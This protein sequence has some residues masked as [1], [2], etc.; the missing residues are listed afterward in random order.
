MPIHTWTRRGFWVFA[1]LHLTLWTIVPICIQPNPPLD[2]VEVVA[3]GHE[4]ELGYQKHPP[5]VAWLAEVARLA[6]GTD[7]LWP[8]Y[9]L[10][11]LCVVTAFWAVW[12][13]GLEVADPPRA[14]A[15]VLVLEATGRYTWMTFEFNHSLVDLPCIALSALF[16]YRA[17]ARRRLRWWLAAGA[18][19]GIGVMAKYTILLLAAAVFLLLLSSPRARRRATGP[20]PACA[21]GVAALII[22][23]HVVWL[24]ANGFPTIA[25]ISERGRSH[26]TALGRI[27]QPF[28]FLGRQLL[29]LEFLLL[30][31]LLLVA[32]PPRL[33][34]LDADG[35]FTRQFLLAIGLGPG[36][37]LALASVVTGMHLRPAWGM[38]LWSALGV[39]VLFCLDTRSAPV[40]LRRAVLSCALFAAINVLLGLAEGVAGPYW[41]GKGFRTH[42][43]G[44]LL[45]TR[46]TEAWDQRFAV[47]LPLVAGER[48]LAGNVA[49]FAPS[50]PSVLT[51]GGL[52]SAT[53]DEAACPW[54]SIADFRKRGGVLVWSV[55]RQ[56]PQLPPELRA[57]FPTAEMLPT[58]TLPWQTGA[59]VAPVRVGVALVAPLAR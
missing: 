42:F 12:Q 21:L 44:R 5:L 3:W 34:S 53:L 46:V 40:M 57:Q 59:P 28:D 32:W 38:P 2:T 58:L 13:L 24:A 47:P 20:G 11:Q 7:A 33:R 14:L 49:F 51:D 31:L 4:W 9:L 19:F 10:G 18:A 48:W 56:G 27:L 50:R 45:A 43:P 15:S 26:A 35:R 54:T 22:L 25:Y 16:L 6:G 1:A 52:G 37:V 8:I 41:E 17:L 23:P 36:V 55:D 29:M 30:A 39:L